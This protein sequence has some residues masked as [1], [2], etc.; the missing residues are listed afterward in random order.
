MRIE[1]AGRPI[2]DPVE[3]V[4]RYLRE[5]ERDI[6]DYDLH[7]QDSRD[8]V[9]A[10]DVL[11]TKGVSSRIAGG[12]LQY[13]I[14]N[15]PTAPWRDVPHDAHLADADPDE[16]GG[17]YDAAEA[18]HMHFFS[19]RRRGI[20]PAKISKVLHLKR[21]ALYPILDGRIDSIYEES[22]REA[23]KAI[24]GRR[25]RHGKLYWAAIREDVIAN[26]EQLGAIR[27]EL[28]GRGEPEALAVH[29]TDVRL[30]DILAWELVAH[31]RRG[32]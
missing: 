18:L 15:S 21:P 14:D 20:S 8:A 17:L 19:G 32:R 3:V 29:L 2:D 26:A 10:R 25:G 16:E 4:A 12:E 13:F 9:T 1:L 5:H 23:S 27:D 31:L 30:L 11:A 7:E 28:G 22:A 24:D 6:R